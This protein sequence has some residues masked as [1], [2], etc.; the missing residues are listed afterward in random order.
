MNETKESRDSVRFLNDLGD[1]AGLGNQPK[2]F[3]FGRKLQNPNVR[4]P[5]S[6]R[7]ETNSEDNLSSFLAALGAQAAQAGQ[8]LSNEK[9]KKGVLT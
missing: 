5:L 4:D 8:H 7:I 2:A 3:F 1:N 6:S 9:T